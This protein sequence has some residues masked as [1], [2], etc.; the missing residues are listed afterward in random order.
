MGGIVSAKLRV[1]ST[2]IDECRLCGSGTDSPTHVLTDCAKTAAR[3]ALFDSFL[4][5]ISSQLQKEFRVCPPDLRGKWIL[6]VYMIPLRP[7]VD[8]YRIF[9]RGDSVVQPVRKEQRS[10]CERAQ[11]EFRAIA[12]NTEI[13]SYA[14]FT[15][16]SV[17]PPVEE[18]REPRTCG[19]GYVVMRSFKAVL[20][21]G[22]M[23]GDN[24]INVGEIS[25]ILSALRSLKQMFYKN[26]RP[27]YTFLQTVTPP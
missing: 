8:H 10:E 21:G 27:D 23:L 9:E 16:G 2:S 11:R 3:V 24:D 20:R 17:F 1:M 22:V 12:S 7:E 4:G 14:V 26:D 5:D 6:T 25:A 13:G 19:A 15:D 18:S